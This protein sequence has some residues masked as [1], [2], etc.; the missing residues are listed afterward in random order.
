MTMHTIL[1]LLFH[2]LNWLNLIIHITPAQTWLN[3]IGRNPC[4]SDVPL[5]PSLF[6]YKSN[7]LSHSKFSVLHASS[8]HLSSHS[9]EV[10]VFWPVSQQSISLAIG[11]V[12]DPISLSQ[13]ATSVFVL[14]TLILV[15]F[16]LSYLV[17]SHSC[18]GHC[19]YYLSLWLLSSTG[20]CSCTFD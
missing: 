9:Q 18:E 14:T 5:L 12:S 2:T 17:L 19:L 4:C 1:T 3:P 16:T 15:S 6:L 20:V 13:L 7:S 10:L 8:T 11:C